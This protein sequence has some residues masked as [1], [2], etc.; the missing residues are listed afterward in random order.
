[1]EGSK[2]NQGGVGGARVQSVAARGA[3]LVEL[4][5][6]HGR[7][8][9]ACFR[10]GDVIRE[11][12][13]HFNNRVARMLR[14]D[15]RKR[16]NLRPI[17]AAIELGVLSLEELLSL[18]RWRDAVADN[19]VVNTGLDAYL[20]SQWKASGLTAQHYLGL[21]D[22]TTPTIAAGDTMA[23]HAGWSEFTE[24]QPQ[25]SDQRHDL[26]AALGA[27]SAQSVTTSSPLEFIVTDDTLDVNGAFS[28][29]GDSLGGAAGTLITAGTFTQGNKSVDTDD[30]LSVDITFTQAAA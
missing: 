19:L 30:V 15:W 16:F 29:T 13:Q 27:V 5:G 12:D 3:G 22:G 23:S 14:Q 17:A 26:T 18:E 9:F 28:T 11:L 6:H 20:S 24:Y 25:S 10:M 4:A 8:D 7:Y 21:I 2:M 1:M